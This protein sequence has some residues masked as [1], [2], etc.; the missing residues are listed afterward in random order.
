MGLIK[1]FREFAVRGNVIDMAVGIIIGG[2]F[3][4]IVSSLVT[5]VIMPPIGVLLG[6]V[7]FT[8]LSV[9]LK[10]KTETTAAV[11]LNYGIFI[12]TIV[13]FVIVAFV[14]FLVIRQMN[15]LKKKPVTV[16]V[17]AEPTIKECPKCFTQ[18]PVKATRC[19]NCT[20][21]L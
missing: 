10:E 21:E 20:S 11:T 8:S 19:P 18:I 15:R 13:D 4:K 3:G 2:A 5:D 14:I 1:E 9:V 16:V 12:N 6:N 7:D 17:A